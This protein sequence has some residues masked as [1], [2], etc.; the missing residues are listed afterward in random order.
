MACCRL[1]LMKS[2][3]II[4]GEK[5]EGKTTLLLTR[6]KDTEGFVTIHRGNE[7]YLHSLFDGKEELL[8]THRPVFPCFWNNWS[9]NQNAFDRANEILSKTKT[10]PLI[11]DEVG[12]MET[13]G[14]G[15]APFLEK[16]DNYNGDLI[17][18]CRREF[19]ERVTA[20]F[21]PFHKPLIISVSPSS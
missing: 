20:K 1:S 4:T 16:I 10:S 15:F 6:F 7:Y 21:F 8:L 12:M 18:T 14:K 2:F 19:I 17:I 11:L 3:R 5:G 13:E 9:V